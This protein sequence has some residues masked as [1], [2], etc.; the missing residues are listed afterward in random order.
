MSLREMALDTILSQMMVLR[1]PLLLEE[2]VA[3]VILL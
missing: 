3:K 2:W 1:M